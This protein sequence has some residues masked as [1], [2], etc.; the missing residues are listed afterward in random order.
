MRPTLVTLIVIGIVALFTW[1]TRHEWIVRHRDANTYGGRFV[2]LN[3]D[4]LASKT[5][6]FGVGGSGVTVESCA[7]ADATFHLRIVDADGTCRHD[8]FYAVIRRTPLSRLRIGGFESKRIEWL[9]FVAL[10]RTLRAEI[11]FN[12]DSRGSAGHF[13]YEVTWLKKTSD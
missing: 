11:P 5:S 10:K 2:G 4:S 13:T 8:Q 3:K 6:A 7:V 1:A 9:R 12:E